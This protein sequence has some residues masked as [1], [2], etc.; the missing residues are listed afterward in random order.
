MADGQTATISV[1]HSA[2]KMT[3]YRIEYKI[4]DNGR[5]GGKI[6]VNDYGVAPTATYSTYS[7]IQDGGW[8]VMREAN[9]RRGFGGLTVKF[10]LNQAVDSSCGGTIW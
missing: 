3:I 1:T 2:D 10:T 9:I 4:E 5:T 6:W 8:H 7:A